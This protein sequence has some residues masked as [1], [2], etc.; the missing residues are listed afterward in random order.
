M[1]QFRVPVRSM[2]QFNGVAS[3]MAA[4]MTSK[5]RLWA[6]ARHEEVEKIPCSPWLRQALHIFYDDFTTD[7]VELA[8]RAARSDELDLDPLSSPARMCRTSSGT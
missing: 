7:P 5:E 2:A 6:A 8:L 3:Q 4:T 1:V